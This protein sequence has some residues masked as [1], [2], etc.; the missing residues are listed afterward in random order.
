MKISKSSICLFTLAVML[1]LTSLAWSQQQ[2]AE[3]E[4]VPNELLIKF[5]DWTHPAESL[6]A[7]FL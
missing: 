2:G 4:Y 3:Q 1:F 6:L 7:V 5:F